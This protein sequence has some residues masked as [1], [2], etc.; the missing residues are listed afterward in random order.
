MRDEGRMRDEGPEMGAGLEFENITAGYGEIPVLR[1]FSLRVAAG[2][3][4][5]VIGPNGCGKSTLL[6]CA[7]GLLE[8]LRGRVLLDAQPIALLSDRERARR[9]ALLPQSFE[10]GG[11]LAVE[12]MVALG[13]TPYLPAY[14]ALGARDHEVIER[15]LHAT[16]VVALRRRA[17]GSLSGGERQRVM[18][19]RALA[20]EPRALLLDE[21]TS[22]LDIRYQHEILGLVLRLARESG[23]MTILV[24]HQI[25]L[26]AAAADRLVLLA[27]EGSTRALGAPA[28]VMTEA[29]LEAVY[30]MPLRVETG[31]RNGR[32]RAQSDWDFGK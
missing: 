15:C 19:A 30:G 5:A 16:D 10:G 11:E 7:A 1:D 21:P 26:A 13:R 32:P 22:N 9:L 3:V 14:G 17:V 4:V 28:E 20:Q 6:R 2:E 12:T 29:N 8:P 25:N 18:L 23:L 24:L 27:E 31:G